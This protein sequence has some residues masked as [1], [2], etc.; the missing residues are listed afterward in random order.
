MVEQPGTTFDDPRL[1]GAESQY[2]GPCGLP[3]P[4]GVT[5]IL[6]TNGDDVLRGTSGNDKLYGGKGQDTA[7][8]SGAFHEYELRFR[9]EGWDYVLADKVSGRDG[10]DL[11]NLHGVNR[12]EFADLVVLLD[13]WGGAQLEDGTPLLPPCLLMF[14]ADDGSTTVAVDATLTDAS[15]VDQT[16]LVGVAITPATAA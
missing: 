12:V 15:I 8:Y 3:P 6:G 16:A 1:D 13:D 7:V 5:A 11:L 14:P 2:G 4:P 9:P 10:T